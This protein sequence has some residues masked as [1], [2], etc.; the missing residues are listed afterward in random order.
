MQAA[1]YAFGLL[2]GEALFNLE[3]H[4]RK[5]NEMSGEVIFWEDRL[6]T[7]LFAAG[8]ATPPKDVLDRVELS[9]F[10][11]VKETRKK[12]ARFGWKRLL[13]GVIVVKLSL[14]SIWYVVQS[15]RSV[16]AV[17]PSQAIEAPVLR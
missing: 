2:D 10:G 1:E 4:L 15:S 3:Q 5:D 13:V 6:P 7:T 8:R 9:L 11:S 14:L 16:D 12:P 17:R